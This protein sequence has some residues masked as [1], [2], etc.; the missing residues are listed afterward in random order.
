MENLRLISAVSSLE[1]FRMNVTNN[2]C[3]LN[4]KVGFTA[5]MP[6]SSTYWS[7]DVMVFSKVITNIGGGYNSNTGI[8]TAPVAGMYHFFLNLVGYDTKSIDLHVVSN[9][10]SKVTAMSEASASSTYQT[11]TNM[12]VVRLEQDDTVWIKRKSGSGYYSDSIPY[13]TFS[14]FLI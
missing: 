2:H 11:G 10:N 4:K 6:S 3:D 12:L 1:V 9:G 14:G 5:G 13:T 8:F 7:S